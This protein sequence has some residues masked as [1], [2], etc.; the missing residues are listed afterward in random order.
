M[1]TDFRLSDL[2]KTH[3]NSHDRT[4]TGLALDSRKVN[5]GDLFFA[6][7]GAKIDGKNYIADAIQ[8]GAA[9]IVTEGETVGVQKNTGNITIVTLPNLRSRL[10]EIAAQFYGYPSSKL[11]VIG[12][13]GTNG[14]T[15]ITHFLAKA[16]SARQYACGVI[17]TLGNG[18]VDNLS[19][20]INTTPDA[21]SL[22][23]TFA[24]LIEQNARAVAMEVSSHALVQHRVVGTAF[25]IA[26]FT[27]L[28]RDHLDYH[29]T[30]EEYALAKRHLFT[31]DNLGAAVINCDDEYGQTLI[32]ELSPNLSVY[33]FSL[34]ND[35]FNVPLVRA[36]KI[37]IQN[38]KT[39]VTVATPWGNGVLETNLL[40]AFNVSNLL[41]VLTVLGI[42]GLDLTVILEELAQLKTVTGRME[43]FGGD[44]KPL[45]VVDYAHTPDA[46]ERTLN[47]LREHCN[48]KLWCVF[49]CG[50]DR[51][52]GKR[53]L[54]GKIVE[55][56]AD[57]Y[58]ITNDNPRTEDPKKIAADIVA[59]LEQPQTTVIELDRRLAI[60]QAITSAKVG[61]VILIAGKGHEDY[62]IIGQERLPF[63]DAEIVKEIL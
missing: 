10:G 41:A 59:G 62:Q 49:G 1:S 18:F 56:N 17:G 57:H 20:V 21:I 27:N 52:S 6:Y 24:Q 25:D 12:I 31:W 8:R 14:K 5:H 36:K 44:D 7:A 34:K 3:L 29:Q 50:G 48:G 22:H 39:R 28:T 53:S 38:G 37:K 63:S 9:A 51:D 4:I 15:S 46:L 54:M 61:D 23:Q 33:G 42:M 11:T 58:I 40:G 47:A 16:L 30:M 26:V 19:P 32:R 35:D 45:V 43:M 60:E 13:T 2:L 55:E